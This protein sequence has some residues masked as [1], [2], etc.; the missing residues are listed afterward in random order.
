MP[1]TRNW[2]ISWIYVKTAVGV[3]DSSVSYATWR[4]LFAYRHF[5]FVHTYIY[6]ALSFP[7][8]RFVLN[9]V[10]IYTDWQ[11]K[12]YRLSLPTVLKETQKFD[13]CYT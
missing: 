1:N 13:I 6:P 11:K 12:R 5:M 10:Y 4:H 7:A 3:P 2:P 8:S 9:V